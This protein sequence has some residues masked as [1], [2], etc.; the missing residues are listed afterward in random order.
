MLPTPSLITAEF[1]NELMSHPSIDG[2]HSPQ[3]YLP[4]EPEEILHSGDYNTEVDVIIGNQQ[5][6]VLQRKRLISDVFTITEKA[7][8]MTRAFTWLKVSTSAFTQLRH[9]AKRALTPW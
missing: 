3:P 5:K 2:A 9:C 4:R 6:V 8:T 1:M 7:P